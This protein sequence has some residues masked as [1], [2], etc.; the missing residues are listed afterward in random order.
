[1]NRPDPSEYHPFFNGY[2]QKVPDGNF[3]QI[4]EENSSQLESFF[5]SINKNKADYIYDPGKWTIRQM[6][7][8]MSDTERVM[9]YRALAISRGDIH[10]TL[11]SMDQDLYT[12]HAHIGNRSID[13]LVN[14]LMVVR[15]ATG[16]LF[17]NMTDEQS[18]YKGKV[19]DNDLTPRALG[20]IIV[21]HAI[22]HMN[23]VNERYL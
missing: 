21:G 1:M 3:L 15:K 22:H 12:S 7:L 9:S 14:E 20:Y 8:H 18:E 19:L 16:F 10:A 4:L 17:R 5:R 11:S 2:I 13:D 23:I 6:I